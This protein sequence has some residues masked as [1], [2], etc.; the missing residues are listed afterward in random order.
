DAADPEIAH[1]PGGGGGGLPELGDDGPM[2]EA[3]ELH[4]RLVCTLRAN[5]A[6]VA[7]PRLP[8]RHARILREH[9]GLAGCW[10][11]AA[12]E[13][14]ED[15]RRNPM[16]SGPSQTATFDR[17]EAKA[18]RSFPNIAAARR[19]T[20]ETLLRLRDLLRRDVPSDTSVVVFGSLARGE[21]TPKSDVD[22]T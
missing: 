8:P 1:A 18:E 20:A 12:R 11:E 16:T 5:G 3:R 19:L 17:L 22:W 2:F 6:I 15:A 14:C 7:R 13:R 21:Y 10:V 9:A 4:D